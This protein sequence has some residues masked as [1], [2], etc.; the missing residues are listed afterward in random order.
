MYTIISTSKCTENSDHVKLVVRNT[1]GE[2][3]MAKK[4]SA[5]LHDVLML[6]QFATIVRN[7]IAKAMV[8]STLKFVPVEHIF[9]EK[10]QDKCTMVVVHGESAFVTARQTLSEYKD[11]LTFKERFQILIHVAN[12]IKFFHSRSWVH[13]ALNWDNVYWD[14][15]TGKFAVGDFNRS[16]T[17]VSMPT[18]SHQFKDCTIASDVADFG[19]MIFEAITYTKQGTSWLVHLSHSALHDYLAKRCAPSK[20]QS[21]LARMLCSNPL[22]R[23][24][25]EDITLHLKEVLLGLSNKKILVLGTSQSGKTTFV[26]Q[27]N[28]MLHRTTT[29]EGLCTHEYYLL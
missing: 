12:C 8:Y 29:M 27:L 2:V 17:K 13:G 1:L 7:D 16:L 19:T 24:N 3:R 4:C 22:K 25:I 14:K 21:L 26:K 15:P 11:R 23:M 28:E 18:I 10:D 6:F 5:P 20:I 9:V